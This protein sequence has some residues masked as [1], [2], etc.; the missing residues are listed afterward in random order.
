MAGQMDMGAILGEQLLNAAKVMEEQVD[1]QI[2]NLDNMDEDELEVIK[3][4][5]IG[6]KSFFCNH[7]CYRFV[8]VEMMKKHQEKKADWKLQGHGEYQEIP[9]EKEFFPVTKNSENCVIHFYREETFRCKIVDK[10]LNILA[11]KHIE[12]KFCKINAEKT[13]FLCE[14]LKIRVIPS[15]LLIKDQQTTG[16]IMGFTELG[17]TD[18]FT[19]EMLEWRIA[20]VS[21]KW[22]IVKQLI[23]AFSAG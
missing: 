12:T 6:K 8:F 10:H 1:Q 22:L 14:R 9:E 16:H 5:R 20:H 4:R 18:E 15:I 7:V 13:P 17:N 19:T 3:R 21:V 11:K 23:L 2:A